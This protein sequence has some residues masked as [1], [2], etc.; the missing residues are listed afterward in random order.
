MDDELPY[1]GNPD[2][3]V[4]VGIVPPLYRVKAAATISP[5]SKDLRWLRELLDPWHHTFYMQNR[6]QSLT[7]YLVY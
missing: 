7:I 3:V 4:L 2:S 1:F 6:Q 5:S